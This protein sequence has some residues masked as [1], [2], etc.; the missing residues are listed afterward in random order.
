MMYQG[1]GIA[2]MAALEDQSVDHVI[3]DPPYSEHTHRNGRKGSRR[4]G[5]PR[6]LKRRA[7]GSGHA[8]RA[9][10]V[11]RTLGFEPVDDDLAAAAS[12]QFARVARRWVVVF[13][14]VENVAL[15]ATALSGAGL[16]YVRTCA[17][18]KPGAPPQFSGDR[19]AVGFE[20]IVLAH[21]SG[22]K[23]WNG[24][25]KHGVWTV[26]RCGGD[27][28]TEH[29]TQ[30]PLELMEALVRDF[31]DPGELICDPFAG[32]GSTGVAAK[33]LGR[34]FIG[35]EMQP[36]YAELARRRIE[37]TREQLDLLAGAG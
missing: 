33:R 12:E 28:R 37:D 34:E 16:E 1:D 26:P 4:F 32:S 15:W 11:E 24:G 3:T 5:I 6:D 18:V 31:T 9:I 23:R 30:K 14:D 19:P 29:T 8:G 36:Q 27:E 10:A 13:S 35:W 21:R 17:W 2:G 20:C 7:N 22:E 25:G